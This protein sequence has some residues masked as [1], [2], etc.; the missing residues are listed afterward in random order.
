VRLRLKTRGKTAGVIKKKC[1]ENDRPAGVR[2]IQAGF[3]FLRGDKYMLVPLLTFLGENTWRRGIALPTKKSSAFG[4]R[5]TGSS[6]SSKEEE[7]DDEV[8]GSATMR[9]KTGAISCE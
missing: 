8:L 9:A 1:R 5:E 2:T 4:A 3:R 7:D 6:G